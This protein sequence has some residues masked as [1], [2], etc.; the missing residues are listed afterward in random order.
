MPTVLIIDDEPEQV[1]MLR[2]ILGD[3]DYDLSIASSGA[4]SRTLLRDDGRNV[5]ADPREDLAC[6]S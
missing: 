2:E 5:D 1:S 4:E 3:A 6:L